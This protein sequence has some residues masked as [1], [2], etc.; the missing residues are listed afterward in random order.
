MTAR[1]FKKCYHYHNVPAAIIIPCP[2]CSYCSWVVNVMEGGV[3]VLRCQANEG[4]RMS[5]ISTHKCDMYIESEP[6]DSEEIP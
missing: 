2:C 5:V 3:N 4:K 1:E 6:H